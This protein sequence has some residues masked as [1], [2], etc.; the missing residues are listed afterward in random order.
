[1]DIEVKEEISIDNP[2]M[3]T[4]GNAEFKKE[5]FIENTHLE[6]SEEVSE[7]SDSSEVKTETPGEADSKLTTYSSEDKT[8]VT[9]GD[10]VD[11]KL[12]IANEQTNNDQIGNIKEETCEKEESI[13]KEELPVNEVKNKSGN[14]ATET[15]VKDG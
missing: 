15:V 1:M 6:K 2:K 13:V 9:V 11:S 3:E 5:D 7:I 10:Q 12:E 4:L 8:N 14:E